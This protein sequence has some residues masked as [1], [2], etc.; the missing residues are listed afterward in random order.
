MKII[1]P[2][3]A[4]LFLAAGCMQPFHT[5]EIMEFE[6]LNYPFSVKKAQ[7][8]NGVTV[9]YAEQGTGPQTIIF[10]HGLGSYMPAWK[11]NIEHLQAHYRCIA[12]DLPGYGKSSKGP[13]PGTMS[14]YAET[15]SQFVAALQLGKVVIAGHS[16]GGQIAMVTALQYPEIVQKLVL[17]APAGFEVFDEGEK[18]WF[19]EVVTIESVRLTT[20]QQIHANLVSNF[21]N[22]P[23]DAEFMITDRLAMRA[24][25]DFEW[26]CY[27]IQQSV[28]GM[29]DEPVFNALPK[30]SQPVLVL[31][32][33]NDQLIPNRFLNAGKTE[34]VAQ[35]G[36]A[37][38]PDSRLVMVPK[39]GH[40]MQFEKPDVFNEEVKK[41]LNP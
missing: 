30:I 28:R 34:K 11:K 36:H 14:F 4:L 23:A 22:M 21:Y 19:R 35:A 18:Q 6:N 33:E 13:Y 7:L 26:Y 5:T 29:V 38:L 24:A 12:I 39:C 9:A 10:I 31:Y 3:I 41:F 2:L 1:Y 25:A 15:V 8:P 20:A 40:F 32:G 27:A 17:V 16:M 37:Q